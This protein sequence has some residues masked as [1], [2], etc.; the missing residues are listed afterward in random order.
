MDNGPRCNVR[1][2][3]IDLPASPN[4]AEYIHLDPA[5]VYL[6]ETNVLHAFTDGSCFYGDRSGGWGVR[7]I[8]NGVAKE[9]YGG[10][11]G[12]TNNS[13][14]LEAIKQALLARRRPEAPMI[15]YSDSQY[16]IGALT[17]WHYRWARNYWRTSKGSAVKNVELIQSI[18]PL[19]TDNVQMRWVKGH[20]GHVHNERADEL[21]SLGR[22]TYGRVSDD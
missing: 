19:V 22:A 9:I 20:R 21:A 8:W 18:I 14:E 13:M 12:Q 11:T 4:D 2:L 15:I 17:E 6:L 1:K 16:C 5:D 3:E 7:L 10:A